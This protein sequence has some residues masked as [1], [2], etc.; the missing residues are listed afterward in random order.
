V[1]K[2][3]TD[4]ED[5]KLILQLLLEERFPRIWVP[6]EEERDVRQLLLDRHHRVRAR[7][8][9]KNQL[10]AL[11]MNQ[12][13]QKGRWLWTEKGRAMLAGLSMSEHTARRRDYLLR[14][15]AELDGEIAGMDLLVMTEVARRPAAL[16][17]KTH[18]GV[19]PQT[20]LA[21]VLTLGEVSR[22]HSAR[23]VSAYLGLVPTE[24]SSGGKQRLGHIS[25]QGSSLMRFL[26]VE[27]GQT[28]AKKDPELKRAYKRM[29]V[30]K[31]NKAVAKVMVARRLAV[32]LYWMLREQWTYTQLVE[33]VG[34]PESSCGKR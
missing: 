27:A 34:K 29:W 26:L 2:K 13:V 28:A 12:G 33:H 31:G 9:F 5:A 23:A 15:V 30:R 18:P 3:K 25:K 1:G 21:T 19:G 32:R 24:Y 6:T 8:A 22:F 16:L 7:T 10:Q 14:R 4:R 11:A 17:L 20:A